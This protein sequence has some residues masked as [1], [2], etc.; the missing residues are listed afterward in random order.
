MK[1]NTITID[2]AKNI[3]Q[4]AGFNDS[5]HRVFNKRVNRTQLV[6]FLSN[7]EP[8]LI[9]IEACYSAH[10]WGRLL[11]S[12]GHTVKL[13]PAQHVTP[14]VRGNKND[15]NDALAIYEA[16]CRPNIKFVPIKTESQQETL[17]LHKRRE[18]LL[19]ARITCSNQLRG[20]LVDFGI[21]FPEGIKAFEL[22][23][24]AL[25]TE[26]T[27]RPLVKEMVEEDFAEFKLLKTRIKAIEAKL[28][29][30]IELDANANIIQSI[31]GVG[32]LNASAFAASIG[33]GEAF[34]K[35]NDM[36]VWLGL[37][38][39]QYASGVTNRM[40]GITKRGNPYLR[41]LLINGARALV[42]KCKSKTNKTTDALSLWINQLLERKHFNC[43]VVATACKLARLMWTLLQKQQMY[44]PSSGNV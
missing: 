3:F 43:V 31:P 38:P 24:S 5:H 29:R 20:L 17:M 44:K 4:L 32:V 14:F 19:K 12:F 23:V 37:T 13:I 1:V 36:A 7:H 41:K 2:L 34:K 28:R 42:S 30:H 21:I 11:G 16:S 33:R 40:S 15:S 18:R 26:D 6:D 27:L 25:L 8:C 9:V 39:K 35:G 22:S 10:Y